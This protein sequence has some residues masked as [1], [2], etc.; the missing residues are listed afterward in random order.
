MT[1]VAAKVPTRPTMY[2]TE[3]GNFSRCRRPCTKDDGP[4]KMAKEPSMVIEPKAN[5]R[6]NFCGA[7]GRS[8]RKEND[9]EMRKTPTKKTPANCA[10]LAGDMARAERPERPCV[11]LPAPAVAAAFTEPAAAAALAFAACALAAPRA[12]ASESF[13]WDLPWKSL[14][15]CDAFLP[16][17]EMAEEACAAPSATRERLREISPWRPFACSPH[18]ADLARSAAWATPSRASLVALVTCFFT[19]PA[20]AFAQEA[21]L[22]SASPPL[23]TSTDSSPAVCTW[24]CGTTS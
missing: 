4:F 1:M 11:N 9:M 24:P 13:C 21:H 8:G 16:L 5:S 15:S 12:L 3:N 7:I 2:A 22:G 20:A 18:S 23:S 19:R 10:S 14:A 17:S 6:A